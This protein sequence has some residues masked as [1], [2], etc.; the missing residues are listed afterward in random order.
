MSDGAP[1]KFFTFAKRLT[2]RAFLL[3]VIVG[4][5]W[6]VIDRELVTFSSPTK[7]ASIISTDVYNLLCGGCEKI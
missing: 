4:G 5:V 3:C 2:K 6:Y 7:A 1:L